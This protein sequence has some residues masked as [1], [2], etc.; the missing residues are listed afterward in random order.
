MLVRYSA[1]AATCHERIAIAGKKTE[2]REKDFGAFVRGVMD[3][4]V[5]TEPETRNKALRRTYKSSYE[6]S[7]RLLGKSQSRIRKQ[8]M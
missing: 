5:N 7:C 2:E 4:T 3:D 6:R 1:K 8:A